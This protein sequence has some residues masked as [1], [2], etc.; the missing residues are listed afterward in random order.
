MRKPPFPNLKCEDVKKISQKHILI[1]IAV[2]L[3]P[4][5]FFSEVFDI[6][7]CELKPPPSRPQDTITFLLI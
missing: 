6:H 5:K 4:K 7:F 1:S 3:T 2:D